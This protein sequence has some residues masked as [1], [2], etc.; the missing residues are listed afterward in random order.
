MPDI[1][2]QVRIVQSSNAIGNLVTF[3]QKVAREKEGRTRYLRTSPR[4][5]LQYP[6]PLPTVGL[7][8]GKMP[9]SLQERVHEVVHQNAT[10]ALVTV[11]SVKLE[12]LK[13]HL[14]LK[15]LK[16]SLELFVV[17][18]HGTVPVTRSDGRLFCTMKSSS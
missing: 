12:L 10:D 2:E 5:S 11:E 4:G 1:P 18:A 8:S 14:E 17:P 15:L 6:T 16:L 13:L 7:A 3:D 9:H